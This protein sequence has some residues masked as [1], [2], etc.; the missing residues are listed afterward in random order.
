VSD[1]SDSRGRIFIAARM[2]A[3]LLL[4]PCPGSPVVLPVAAEPD[5]VVDAVRLSQTWFLRWE[6][7]PPDSCALVEGCIGA[8]GYRKLIRFTTQTANIGSTDLV[9]GSPEGNPLFEWSEC[10]GH[11][12]FGDYSSHVLLDAEGALVAPG[13]KTGF[14]LLDNDRYI[15]EPWVPLNPTYTCDFQGLTRGWYDIYYSVLDCQWI[16]VTGIP[17]G[18]YQ[19]RLT[20]N[21]EGVLAESDYLNNGATVWVS[22]FEPLGLV[23]RPDGHL[24]PGA[25]LVAEHSG[26][27]VR[28]LYDTATCP[29]PEYNL[30][31]GDQ[32]SLASYQYL[33][34]FCDLGTDGEENVALADPPLGGL[35]WFVVVGHDGEVEGGHGFD[36][37]GVQRPLTGVGFCGVT[38]S[39]PTLACQP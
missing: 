26:A 15:D 7:F 30:Y 39:R 2:A 3:A 18:D 25:P 16:D 12:H 34:S 38:R 23:H 32:V 36:S 11:Y 29:A 28:V 4:L 37:L 19:L 20:V 33:G 6:Y 10:H 22:V 5:L 21:P 31:W 14:C 17:D 24:A 9:L 27:D 1:L 13:F 35:L 8:A